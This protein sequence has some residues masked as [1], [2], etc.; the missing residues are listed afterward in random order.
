[1]VF[2]G[3]IKNGN[4]LFDEPVDLPEGAAVRVELVAGPLDE[5]SLSALPVED[6]IAA[7]WRDVS[8]QEWAVLPADLSS[9]IDHYIYGVP[10]R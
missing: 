4:V 1:M 9:N 6:E 7:I 8:H 10:K 2:H 5:K 3:H